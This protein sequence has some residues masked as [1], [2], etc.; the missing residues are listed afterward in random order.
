MRISSCCAVNSAP[1]R[2]PAGEKQISSFSRPPSCSM[3]QA[4][5]HLPVA[6]DVNAMIGGGILPHS[7]QSR[8]GHLGQERSMRPKST[9]HTTAG[10]L[11]SSSQE[12]ARSRTANTAKGE[13]LIRTVSASMPAS[14]ATQMLRAPTFGGGPVNGITSQTISALA[15][16]FSSFCASLSVFTTPIS[17]SKGPSISGLLLAVTLKTRAQWGDVASGGM[18][19]DRVLARRRVDASKVHFAVIVDFPQC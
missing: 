11:I 13:G 7:S 17:V 15:L 8:L 10:S 6:R 19:R 2:S 12:R 5:V 14:T 3:G 16:A 18:A 4:A 1:S 9:S